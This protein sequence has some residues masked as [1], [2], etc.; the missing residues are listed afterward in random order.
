V[1][2]LSGLLFAFGGYTAS[3]YI[4]PVYQASTT[5]LINNALSTRTQLDYDSLVTSELLARAYA[6]LLRKRPVLEIVIAN[7]Q[8]NIDAA[9]LQSQVKVTS[10]R[11]LQLLTLTVEDSDPQRVA[12]IANEIARV[13]SEQSRN[14]LADRYSRQLLVVVEEARAPGRQLQPKP[15]QYALLAGIVGA[16]LA[17]A[18]VVLIGILDSSLR[19][20]QQLEEILEAPVL[21]AVPV[22][23][24]RVPIVFKAGDVSTP[25]AE[26]YRMLRT[27]LEFIEADT[28]LRTLLVASG[29]PGEGKST[30]AANLA[31]TLAQSGRRIILVDADLRR[32]TL[33]KF[34]EQSNRCGL[35]TAL[36]HR[37]GEHVG[38][39]LLATGITN[40]RLLTS[41]PLVANPGDLLGSRRMADLLEELRAEADMV[42]VDSPPLLVVADGLILTRGC[43]AVLLVTMAGLA[44]ADMLGQ[45]REQL[46]RAHAQLVGV[47]FNRVPESYNPYYLDYYLHKRGWRE[48]IGRWQGSAADTARSAR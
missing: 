19:T 18:V 38:K 36:L 11:D 37:D 31:A 13:G 2:A 30:T 32:P 12:A 33:H 23:R 43:D 48:R 45:A 47:V 8:L 1:I 22:I 46:S 10:I 26:A 20:P 39:Y 35:T 14:L 29:R 4:T 41:G 25:A 21:A 16:L 42:V 17:G 9:Q 24:D 27:G 34:F 44:E 5:L 7:L 28:P 15:K 40:L 6:E 3:R